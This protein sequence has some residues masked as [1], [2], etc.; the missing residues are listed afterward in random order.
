MKELSYKLLPI[1][2]EAEL[3]KDWDAV[4]KEY[5]DFV[6][7]HAG[8]L[9]CSNTFPVERHMHFTSSKT[10]VEWNVMLI[11][12]NSREYLDA[13]Y[14]F[15][16]NEYGEK[17]IYLIDVFRCSRVTPHYIKRFKSRYLNPKHIAARDEHDIVFAIYTLL[18]PNTVL[19]THKK[20]DYLVHKEGLSIVEQAG[21][22]TI[23]YITFVNREMLRTYQEPFDRM[24]ALMYQIKDNPK[25]KQAY[26]QLKKELEATGLRFPP[27]YASI[28]PRRKDSKEYLNTVIALKK[29]KDVKVKPESNIGNGRPSQQSWISEADIKKLLKK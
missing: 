22:G 21:N 6:G 7:L 9:R 3:S 24:R 18:L 5:I 4:S 2:I 19:S 14:T 29:M 1:Q 8:S 13:Y 17:G 16:T 15:Y 28:K 23:S 20:T 10:G 12:I 27:E 25:A 11:L 26:S